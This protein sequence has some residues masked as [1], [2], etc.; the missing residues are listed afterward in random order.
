MRAQCSIHVDGSRVTEQFDYIAPQFTSGQL[1]T[2]CMPHSFVVWIL[3]I[4]VVLCWGIENKGASINTRR[5]KQMQ[6][7][8]FIKHAAL[9]VRVLQVASSNQ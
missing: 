8:A 7:K 5:E 2:L 1:F 6:T 4:S 3:D 9:S